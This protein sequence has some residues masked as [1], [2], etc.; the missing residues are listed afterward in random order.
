MVINSRIF[1][2]IKID[3]KKI[4]FFG[5][6]IV[7]FPELKNFVLV[8]DE[9]KGTKAGIRW[10]QSIE[11]PGFALPVMNPLDIDATYNP[12]VDDELLKPIGELNPDE[13]L[14]LVTATI[15]SDLTKMSVN[16]KA[17][18]VINAN[19]KKACQV[20]AEGD[21]YPVKYYI[22]ELLKAMKKAGE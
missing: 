7:G 4:I 9:E 18:V 12:Q 2:E 19:E 10:L 14:V 5:N 21:V 1:G 20:I 16:M 22:Y 15:P 17:P 6:G 13:M 8:H 3:E 11:E